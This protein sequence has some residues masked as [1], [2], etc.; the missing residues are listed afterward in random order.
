MTKQQKRKAR[1][2]PII[3]NLFPFPKSDFQQWGILP[4]TPYSS[5]LDTIYSG[6]IRKNQ[7]YRSPVP[8]VDLFCAEIVHE[9]AYQQNPTRPLR[10][11]HSPTSYDT[12]IVAVR[13]Q[14]NSQAY[15][16]KNGIDNFIKADYGR[17]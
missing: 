17:G 4:H 9:P 7:P 1:S 6:K 5:N 11:T 8:T 10:K 15:S 16:I 13:N 12:I 3:D 14:A 2:P